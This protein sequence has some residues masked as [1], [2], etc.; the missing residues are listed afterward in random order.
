MDILEA[1]NE[2]LKR[3]LNIALRRIDDLQSAMQGDSESH[4]S[5]AQLSDRYVLERDYNAPS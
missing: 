5:D 1:E 4:E 3:D 2:A